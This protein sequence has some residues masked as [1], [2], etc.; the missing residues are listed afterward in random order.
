M[1]L[2]AR[3]LSIAY[4]CCDNLGYSKVNLIVNI[5]L[6]SVSISLHISYRWRDADAS[7]SDVWM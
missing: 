2:L 4:P 3:I 1:E 5:P 6:L 7:N